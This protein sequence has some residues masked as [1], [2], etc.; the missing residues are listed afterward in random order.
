MNMKQK[1][2]I[3][4]ECLGIIE[5]RKCIGIEPTQELFTPTLVLKSENFEF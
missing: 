3:L 5:W 2:R 1:S 4:S